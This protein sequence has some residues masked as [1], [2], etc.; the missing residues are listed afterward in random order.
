MLLIIP[1]A[2]GFTSMALAPSA[3]GVSLKDNLTVNNNPAQQD[4][5]IVRISRVTF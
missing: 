2:S 4:T 5:R 3:I 1:R